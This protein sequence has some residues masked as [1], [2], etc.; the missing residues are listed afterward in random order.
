MMLGSC[1]GRHLDAASPTNSQQLI[2]NTLEAMAMKLMIRIKTPKG[3]AAS[4]EKKLRPFIIGLRRVDHE[5]LTSKDD[6]Q[7]LWIIDAGTKDYMR[8]VRNVAMY[9][10]LVHNILNRKKIRKLAKL[11]REQEKE[12]DDML[13]NQTAVEM[14][15]KYDHEKTKKKFISAASQS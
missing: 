11:T 9:D 2:I 3:Y 1:N 8:I 4:T 15:H 12:L 5:I 6:D 10:K 7:I 13:F 14:I